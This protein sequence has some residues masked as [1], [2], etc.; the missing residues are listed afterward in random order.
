MP[1]RLGRMH[2]KFPTAAPMLPTQTRIAKGCGEVIS[3]ESDWT[4]GKYDLG[5][6]SSRRVGG[7]NVAA[8]KDIKPCSVKEGRSLLC[9]PCQ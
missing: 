1:V 9:F 2:V 7:H 8:F 4:P 5:R 6:F 3:L